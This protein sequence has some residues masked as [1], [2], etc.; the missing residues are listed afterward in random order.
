MKLK[1]KKIAPKRPE[2]TDKELYRAALHTLGGEAQTRML[3]EE[4]AELQNAICKFGRERDT[5]EHIAEEIA[6]VQI[7]LEQMMLHFKVETPVVDWRAVK[8][9]RL[10]QRVQEAMRKGSG[11]DENEKSLLS[12]D[13]L[14][15][16]ARRQKP[17]WCS[18]ADGIHAGLLCM[19]DDW[20]CSE[21]TPHIWILDEEANVGVYNVEYMMKCGAKFYLLCPAGYEWSDSTHD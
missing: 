6:D 12:L 8:L 5:A 20:F 15:E 18:D 3:F 21:K 16:M 11:T 14:Q 13:K 1:A 7:M 17:V 2:G 4:M 10:E 9:A 19:R